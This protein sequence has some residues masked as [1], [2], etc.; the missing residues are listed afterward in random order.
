MAYSQI[1]D[2]LPDAHFLNGC[3]IFAFFA[4]GGAALLLAD[5]EVV[6]FGV[7]EINIIGWFEVFPITAER[8]AL[9]VYAWTE[10]LEPFVVASTA[11]VWREEGHTSPVAAGHL[12]KVH[13][14]IRLF[15]SGDRCML[16]LASD[17]NPFVID[18][19]VDEQAIAAILQDLI[20]E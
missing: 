15:D 17:S 5:G 20:S 8:S 7:E 1:I 3:T 10:M 4:G 12:V 14:G 6:C 11:N 19:V 9:N 18:V 16:I 2:R 13:A